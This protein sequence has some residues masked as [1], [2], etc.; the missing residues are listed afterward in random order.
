M[1]VPG[2]VT[3]YLMM[4]PRYIESVFETLTLWL[5]SGHESDWVFLMC[6]AQKL[7]FSVESHL[8][9]LFSDLKPIKILLKF[10]V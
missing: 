4:P 2:K 1:L 6:F 9:L 8:P 10:G 7:H 5:A 3:S